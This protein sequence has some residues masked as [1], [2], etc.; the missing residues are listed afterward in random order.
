M[1]NFAQRLI[2]G[3]VLAFVFIGAVFLSPYS[4]LGLVLLINLLGV[5]EFYLLFQAFN[6]KPVSGLILAFSVFISSVLAILHVWEWSN[7]LINVPVVFILYLSELYN[8]SKYPFQRLAFTFMGIIFVTIPS[9]FLAA[10]G[11]LSGKDG[12]YEPYLVLGF[13]LIVWAHDSGAYIFGKLFGKHKL[14]KSVSPGKTWEGSL[15]GAL[16]A[17]MFSVICAWFYNFIDV[18][19]WLC[20][21]GIVIVAGTYGDLIK[22][23][24]KRSV[25]VKDS[26]TILPGHG[27][28]LDRFDAML[29]AAPFVYMYLVWYYNSGMKP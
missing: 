26:G 19:G 29:G 17:G 10:T 6:P 22:S 11:F 16:S 5:R 25:Q 18:K 12:R 27:G 2:T 1:T 14:F 7:L 20:I 4:F 24:L 8:D 21:A 28:I 15:G 13:T 3:A 9:V 23:M